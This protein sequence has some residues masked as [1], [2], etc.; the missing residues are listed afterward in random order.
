M[1]TIRLAFL[2][3]ATAQLSLSCAGEVGLQGPTGPM[4]AKGDPGIAG[5][6]G[7]VIT[8]CPEEYTQDTSAS[9]ITLCKKGSDEVVRVGT[10]RNAFWMDRYEA[11]IWF[12]P[13]GTGAQYG[14][15][16][17]DYPSTFPQDGQWTKQVYAVSMA[18][19]T[20]SRFLSWHQA[21]E[22]CAASGKVL[23]NQDQWFRAGHG[24][25]NNRTGCNTKSG[26]LQQTGGRTSC[27]SS[28]GVQ[29]QIGN[30]AEYG[31]E[32]YYAVGQNAA[33]QE[34]TWPMG[35]SYYGQEVNNI[36]SGTQLNDGTTGNHLPAASIRGF[37]YNSGGAAAGLW[38]QNLS[39]SP[40]EA[41]NGANASRGFRCVIPR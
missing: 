26:V 16:M 5:V 37:S 18:G 8:P 4:G 2:L 28:W 15:G 27:Q 31:A 20:P 11:S 7:P 10:G 1:T 24:A 33:G 22:A 14:V 39:H 19:A 38:T 23:P 30:V 17:Y 35:G 25:E 36:T 13:D 12:N 41:T 40:I 9:P 29:D 34:G 21:S 3:L 6:P 32:W